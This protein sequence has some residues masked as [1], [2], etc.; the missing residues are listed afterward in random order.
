MSKEHGGIATR[1]EV[2]ATDCNVAWPPKDLPADVD[3]MEVKEAKPGP[4]FDANHDW[5]PRER[6][7]IRRKA[8]SQ[9]YVAR[10]WWK[11]EKWIRTC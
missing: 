4:E 1:R 6:V 11:S 5:N 8:T 10:S 7:I 3:E 9:G 2:V